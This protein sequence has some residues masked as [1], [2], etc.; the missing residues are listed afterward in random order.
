MTW[1]TNWCD[2]V[3]DDL[4][5]FVAEAGAALA[6]AG[7]DISEE[8]RPAEGSSPE[9]ASADDLVHYVVHCGRLSSIGGVWRL[10]SS[11]LEGIVNFI[12]GCRPR[13]AVDIVNCA[14]ADNR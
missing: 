11:G 6:K 5:A 1:L 14:A 9:T 13:V 10:P 7:V 8:D 4:K 3:T 12:T 2:L